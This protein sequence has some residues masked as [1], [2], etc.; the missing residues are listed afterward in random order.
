MNIFG[1]EVCIWLT[2]YLEPAASKYCTFKKVVFLGITRILLATAA[3][4]IPIIIKLT[5]ETF[6]VTLLNLY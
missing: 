2:M 3:K 4:S 6:E 5:C 1:L